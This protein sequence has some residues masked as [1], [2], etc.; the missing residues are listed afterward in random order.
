VRRE[1]Y[2]PLPGITHEEQFVM[3]EGKYGWN[4]GR[5]TATAGPGET[6]ARAPGVAQRQWDAGTTPI[7]LY[8]EH[9]PRLTSAEVF[10]ETR[11]GQS[12]DGCRRIWSDA[13]TI[14]S[15]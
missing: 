15:M 6:L 8:D 2:R 10:F 1:L 11:C 7:R 13:T 12:I 3:L 4:I 14:R 5:E 9:R